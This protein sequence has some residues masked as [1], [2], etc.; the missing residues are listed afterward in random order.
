[1]KKIIE[2]EE[3]MHL[4]CNVCED[5]REHNYLDRHEVDKFLYFDLYNCSICDNIKAHIPKRFEKDLTKHFQ[6]TK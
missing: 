5:F 3:R 1:M 2:Y 6:K 4:Y